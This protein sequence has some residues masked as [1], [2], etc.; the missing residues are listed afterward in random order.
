MSSLYNKLIKLIICRDF[1]CLSYTCT[2]KRYTTQKWNKWVLS[3]FKQLIFG[4]F[5]RFPCFFLCKTHF[6][7]EVKTRI[8][9]SVTY[10][11]LYLILFP[12]LVIYIIFNILLGLKVQVYICCA[13]TMFLSKAKNYPK[14]CSRYIVK[15][16]IGNILEMHRKIQIL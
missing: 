15:T 9:L 10:L 16:I 12:T 14:I 8:H 1:S 7:S 13:W 6:A 11:S 2:D 4:V 5:L 3:F